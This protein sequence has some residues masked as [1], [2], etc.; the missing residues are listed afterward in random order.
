MKL[1]E[2]SVIVITGGSKGIGK[3]CALELA[4]LGCT[5]ILLARNA[6]D[7]EKTKQE[8]EALG[9]KTYTKVCDVSNQ[10]ACK[11]V[12]ETIVN[13]MGRIDVLINNAG[14]GHYSKVEDLSTEDLHRIF[15]TNLY[16]ALWCTQSVLPSMKKAGRGHIVNVSTI[17]SHR[18]IPFFSAYSMTKFALNALT[19]SLRSEVAPYGIGV[20]LICPGLTQTDFQ[21]NA[22]KNQF[23]PPISSRHGMDPKK[24]AKSIRKAIEK[25]CKRVLFTGAGIA[26][27]WINRLCPGFCDRIVDHYFRSHLSPKE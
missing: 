24:V 7:L 18:S 16:G 20:S 10:E 11:A 4:P 2:Q 23:H 15:D 27:V 6:S 12:L 25:N 3:A 8:C 26:L 9:A 5:L 1:H 21:T 22:K 14:Y 13:E 19:E 17:L